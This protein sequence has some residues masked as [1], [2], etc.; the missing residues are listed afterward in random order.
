MRPLDIIVPIYRNADLVKA[1]VDSLLAHRGELPGP[2]ARLV[3]IN[4]SPGDVAVA[5]LLGAYAAGNGDLVVLH[6]EANLGFVQTVN[7]G[8]RLAAEA[9][10]AVLLVN[11][12]TVTFAGTLVQLLL[13]ARADPG[14]GFASPRSN[15]ASLCSWPHLQDTSQ[16]TAQAS[17]RRWATLGSTLPAFHFVPTAVGFYMYIAHEVLA[18]FGPLR[19]D[20][21]VGYE[22]ENDL[23]MRAGKVGY[24]AVLANHAFAFHAG[25]ASFALTGLD[26]AEQ[27]RNN[28]DKLVA[29]HPEFLPLMT[30]YER[31]AHFRAERLLAGLLPDDGGRTRLVF[32]WASVSPQDTAAPFPPVAALAALA[33]RHERHLRVAVVCS[34]RSFEALGLNTQLRI[35]RDEPGASGVHG[36][37]VR[38]ASRLEMADVDRMESLAPVQIYVVCDSSDEDCGPVAAASAAGPL[39]EHIGAHA[40]GLVFISQFARDTFHARHPQSRELPLLARLLPTRLTS[41]AR[42]AARAAAGP[43]LI[44]GSGAPHDGTESAARRLSAAFADVRFIAVGAASTEAGNLTCLVPRDLAASRLEALLAEARAVVLP[45]YAEG[46]NHRL[47]QAL[48]ARRP[49]VVRRTP[50]TEEIL[51]TLDD[52]AGVYLFEVDAGLA[53]ACALALTR[54]S[55]VASDRRA[56][57]WD[58]WI[59]AFAGFC[60]ERAADRRVFERLVGR[61]AAADRLRQA[62]SGPSADRQV[63][64]IPAGGTDTHAASAAVADLDSLLALQ[65]RDFVARAYATLL[66]RPADNAG[67]EFYAGQL[68]DGTDKLDVLRSLSISPEGRA[69]DVRLPGLDARLAA[70]GSFAARIV[71]RVF[72]R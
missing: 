44:L 6:N 63:A 68:R 24:R 1:C 17:Y 46:F 58:G 48:S 3:L 32:D 15:N 50:S 45:S 52:I 54:D 26:L 39:R 21:G 23:V 59:D 4:D 12:D 69:R 49:V 5:S 61:T 43:V 55:S 31:S 2:P 20:F 62:A 65:G 71:K 29:L 41:P 64:P 28:L 9:G 53:A 7:R 56:D 27:R 57:D 30:R 67:L 19:E 18:D 60:R 37:A 34:A 42:P 70:R 11:A 13:A 35:V 14:I 72:G 16:H 10:H 8:L 40:N 36:I 33:R 51:A 25:A 66:C 38:T 22:E 47:L